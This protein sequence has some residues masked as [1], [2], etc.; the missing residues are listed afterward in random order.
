MGEIQGLILMT[1]PPTPL[2]PS[3]PE[4]LLSKGSCD[5]ASYNKS[6][7]YEVT[8][9]LYWED[10]TGETGYNLYKNDVLLVTLDADVSE[11]IDHDTFKERNGYVVN[12]YAIEAFNASGSSNRYEH[13]SE[14]LCKMV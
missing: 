12:W 9:S 3:D 8:I 13:Y 14:V 4:Y 5:Y 2:P 7:T 11:Y 1:P 6:G 10:V